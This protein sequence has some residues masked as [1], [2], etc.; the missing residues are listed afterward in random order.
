LVA[1]RVDIMIEQVNWPLDE[2]TIDVNGGEMLLAMDGLWATVIVSQSRNNVRDFSL[3]D[4]FTGDPNNSSR[5]KQVDIK[6]VIGAAI[7][8]A[9]ET[10][11]K[12]DFDKIC[13]AAWEAA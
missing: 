4:V 1:E 6:E 13:L 3:D 8:E 10:K 12:K 5:Q 7:W 9:A 11:I 2:M